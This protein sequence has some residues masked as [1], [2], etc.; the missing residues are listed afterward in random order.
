MPSSL[1]AQSPSTVQRP[2]ASSA[3]AMR[4]PPKVV[5]SLKESFLLQLSQRPHIDEIVE[6][7]RFGLRKINRFPTLATAERLS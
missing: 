2:R 6:L 5:P 7:A 4:I 1:H 3:L